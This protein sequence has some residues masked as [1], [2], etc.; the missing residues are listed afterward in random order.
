MISLPKKERWRTQPKIIMAKHTLTLIV[1]LALTASSPKELLR[2]DFPTRARHLSRLGILQN[3]FSLDMQF[4]LSHHLPL[5]S[6]LFDTRSSHC[7]QATWIIITHEVLA[8]CISVCITIHSHC[9]CLLLLSVPFI[10]HWREKPGFCILK[11]K[12]FP[13]P[14]FL[15]CLRR[16]RLWSLHHPVLFLQLFHQRK[17]HYGKI[18][19]PY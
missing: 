17:R 19:Q 12:F 15:A 7:C 9:G 6:G 2:E 5:H 8:L 3:M 4:F 10:S 1:Y 14:R 16:A 11:S 13:D 18:S